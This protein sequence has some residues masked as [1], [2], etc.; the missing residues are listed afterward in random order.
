MLMYAINA[1]N[2]MLI[3]NNIDYLNLD[4]KSLRLLKLIHLHGSMSAAANELGVSQSTVSHAVERL[5]SVFNDALFVKAGRGLAPTERLDLMMPSIVDA[6]KALQKVAQ[7][8]HFSPL[9]SDREFLLISN[10]YEH[11]IFVPPLLRRLRIDAPKMKLRTQVSEMKGFKRLITGEVDVEL[12]PKKPPQ[13]NML[14]SQPLI[15]DKPVV[16]FDPSVR[17][18]PLDLSSYLQA[19]H[20]R[21][22]FSVNPNA[23]RTDTA[24]RLLGLKRNVV[25]SAPSF[26]S[27][28]ATVRG[29]D[30][31]AT[32]PSRLLCAELAGL[33][34]VPRPFKMEPLDFAMLWHIKHRDSRP[35]QWFRSLLTGIAA[36][37]N[38]AHSD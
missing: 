18:P 14:V 4:A 35:H 27:L 20:V 5:R 31:L 23:N 16:F 1:V 26:A 17:P 12:T 11:D 32:C 9:T 37:L 38:P 13:D 30:M 2:Y 34:H 33:R 3:M 7:P 22:Q 6:L 19:E 28:V 36:D 10:D 24:L 8:I 29:S 15:Q 25:Y 21:V